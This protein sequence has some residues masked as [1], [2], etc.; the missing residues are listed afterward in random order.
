MPLLLTCFSLRL[1]SLSR[2]LFAGVPPERCRCLAGTPPGLVHR[3]ATLVSRPALHRRLLCLELFLVSF[4][5]PGSS[6]R[7]AAR[8]RTR[9]SRYVPPGSTSSG[10]FWRSLPALV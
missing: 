5:A 1:A 6:S 3:A 7:A 8:H 10:R 9:T 4:E 2:S